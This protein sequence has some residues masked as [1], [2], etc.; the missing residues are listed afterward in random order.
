MALSGAGSG[1][2]AFALKD[3]DPD[4]VGQALV[5]EAAVHGMSSTYLIL[6]IDRDGTR[7]TRIWTDDAKEAL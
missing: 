4:A 6:P 2:F 5:R 7:I 1:I 3:R